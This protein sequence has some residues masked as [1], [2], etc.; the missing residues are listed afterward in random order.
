MDLTT[1]GRDGGAVS[2]D[3]VV[4]VRQSAGSRRFLHRSQCSDWRTD[5]SK[6]ISREPVDAVVEL[7]SLDR[8]TEIQRK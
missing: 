4:E 8:D 1:N 5:E 3:M 2:Q 7:M 6:H